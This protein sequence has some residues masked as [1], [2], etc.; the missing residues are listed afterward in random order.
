VIGR[1][2]VATYCYRSNKR[3]V[4]VADK[5]QSPVAVGAAATSEKPFLNRQEN[6]MSD[7]PESLPSAD[8]LP[9]PAAAALRRLV[10]RCQKTMAHAWMIRT[11]VKHSDEVEDYPDLNE[12]ARTIFDIFRALETQVEDPAGYFK[13]VRKKLSK[14]RAAAVQ[15]EKDAWHASTHTNFQQAAIAAKFLGDQLAELLTEAETHL[16]RPVAPPKFTLPGGFPA[17]VVNNASSDNRPS[18]AESTAE[19]ADESTQPTA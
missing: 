16:P 11:F 3:S 14:L 8:I 10:E 13:V 6:V 7:T 15:F 19:N 18:D 12:M 9:D 4:P 2:S 17:A 1:L 5:Q